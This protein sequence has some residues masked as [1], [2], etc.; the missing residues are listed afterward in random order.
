MTAVEINNKLKLDC[1]KKKAHFSKV[2]TL[3][4]LSDIPANVTDVESFKKLFLKPPN[5]FTNIFL[6]R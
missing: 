4:L 6:P 5:E 3:N 2:L 1:E